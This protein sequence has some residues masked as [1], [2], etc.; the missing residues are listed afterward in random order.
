[1]YKICCLLLILL[2]A[3]LIEVT[4]FIKQTFK[5]NFIKHHR[6]NIRTTHGLHICFMKSVISADIEHNLNPRCF[7]V[8]LFMCAKLCLQYTNKFC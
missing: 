3:V 1:M 2:I 6:I 4:D 8:S 5:F 7:V